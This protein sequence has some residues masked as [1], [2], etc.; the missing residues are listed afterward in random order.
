MAR[1]IVRITDVTLKRSTS[2]AGLYVT[3]DGD[4]VWIPWNHLEEGSVDKDGET[5]DI[6][7]PFWL[8]EKEE[9]EYLDEDE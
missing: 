3:E 7:I 4:E 1:R 9:L 5:G 2:K 6:L 8:A